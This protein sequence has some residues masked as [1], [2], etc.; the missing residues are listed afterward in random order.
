[1][2]ELLVMAP[3]TNEALANKSKPLNAPECA[4]QPTNFQS[5]TSHHLHTCMKPEAESGGF[6]LRRGIAR[7]FLSGP[8]SQCRKG[9]ESVSYGVLWIFLEG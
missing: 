2:H 4:V 3:I 6:L 7:D 9:F 1:M 5:H 8:V